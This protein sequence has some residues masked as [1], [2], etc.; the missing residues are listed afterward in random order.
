MSVE[1]VYEQGC[2]GVPET[3]HSLLKAFSSLDLRPEWLEW[4]RGDPGLPDH[5]QGFG[6]PTVLVEGRDVAGEPANADAGS[7][8]LYRSSDGY[9]RSPSAEMIREALQDWVIAPLQDVGSQN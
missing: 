3:R 7:C 1:L 5:A 2:P 4:E 6:S 9:C 8:R